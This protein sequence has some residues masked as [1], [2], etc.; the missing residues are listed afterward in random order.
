MFVDET[1][2]TAAGGDGG[3]GCL[4]FRR[5]KFVP[6]GGPDG[7]DG[8]HGGSVFLVAD[9]GGSPLL[10]FRYQTRFKAERGQHGQGSNKTGRS[11]RNLELKVPAGT[12]VTDTEGVNLLADLSKELPDKDFVTALPVLEKVRKYLDSHRS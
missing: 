1:V 8:V 12:L 11:G 5:E 2:I 10:A 7:G 9:P 4:S 3:N 6:R